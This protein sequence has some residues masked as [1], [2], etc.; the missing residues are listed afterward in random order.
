[1]PSPPPDVA[2]GRRGIF[3]EWLRLLPQASPGVFG[4][5]ECSRLKHNGQVDII[6]GGVNIYL[7]TDISG[8]Y[9]SALRQ[10]ARDWSDAGPSRRYRPQPHGTVTFLRHRKSAGNGA[11]RFRRGDVHRTS[12]KTGLHLVSVTYGGDSLTQPAPH[13]WSVSVSPVPPRQLTLA[14][15]FV[16]YTTVT[17]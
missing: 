11:A 15:S 14:A 16:R 4:V 7:G 9:A 5:C 13:R 10:F 8:R 12:D 3:P 2:Y 17:A 6:A 1:M